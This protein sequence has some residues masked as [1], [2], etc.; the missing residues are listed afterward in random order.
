MEFPILNIDIFHNNIYCVL[1][2]KELILEYL[3]FR[4]ELFF[5]SDIS[6]WNSIASTLRGVWGRVLKKLYCYQKQLECPACPM[7]SCS[8]FTIFEKKY[9]DAGQY[10]PYIILPILQSPNTVSVTFKFF[11][12]ITAHYDKLLFS[13]LELQNYPILIE[14]KRMEFAIV[15]IQDSCENRIYTQGNPRLKRPRLAEINYEPESVPNILLQFITPLR[16]KSADRLMQ[17]FVWE[18]FI[19]SLLNR[20]RFINVFFN[21]AGWA[22]PAFIPIEGVSLLDPVFEWQEQIRKSFRQQQLMSIGGL[23]GSVKLT[24]V[25]PECYGILKLGAYLHAGKQST[26][27]NGL[28]KINTL[29]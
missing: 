21:N 5:A 8:Y 9:G 29:S 12:W 26:F 28:F 27:G 25:S 13:I 6:A 3:E 1:Y 14:G 18:P 20:I 2:S 4:I 17:D 15:S 11:G 7:T 23:V 22:I 10:H 19:K 24:H 16:Q